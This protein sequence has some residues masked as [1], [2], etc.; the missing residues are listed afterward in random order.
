MM[1]ESLKRSWSTPRPRASP[2]PQ[3]PEQVACPAAPIPS[4]SSLPGPAGALLRSSAA[5][6]HSLPRATENVSHDM[7]GL[8]L[9]SSGSSTLPPGQPPTPARTHRHAAD[10]THPLGAL[11]SAR[12]PAAKWAGDFRTSRRLPRRESLR[13]TN[14]WNPSLKGPR[15]A[16]T[17][18]RGPRHHPNEIGLIYGPISTSSRDRRPGELERKF[19]PVGRVFGADLPLSLPGLFGTPWRQG[20]AGRRPH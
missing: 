17:G 11:G 5:S 19:A 8:L 13:R 12:R 2:K 10:A 4:A 9:S 14:A 7:L 15:V 20:T 1:S 6:T 18:A 16:E 3:A